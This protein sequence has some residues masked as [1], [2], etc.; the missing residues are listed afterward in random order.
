H[1][2]ARTEAQAAL[3]GLREARAK[4]RG[5]YV[6]RKEQVSAARER[7]AAA[8]EKEAG[9]R[10]RV[11]VERNAD[12][13]AYREMLG[14]GLSGARVRNQEEILDKLVELRPERLAELIE[15]NDVEA[16]RHLT[17]LTPDRAKRIVD[18]F[19]EKV[20]PF[21]LEVVPIEDRIAIELDVGPEGD[22]TFK[23][24]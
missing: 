21:A 19:R 8:L 13:L 7:I 6:L 1:E 4:L 15:T 16:V 3:E 9:K 10:V 5:D 24:A 22:P 20:D 12:N 11:R 17:E 18:A 23:D 14:D 2:T